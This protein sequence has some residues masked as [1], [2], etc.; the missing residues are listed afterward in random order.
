MDASFAK[1]LSHCR[2]DSVSRSAVNLCR[3]ARSVLVDNQADTAMLM[4]THCCYLAHNTTRQH[5]STHRVGPLMTHPSWMC[6]HPKG[7]RQRH[8]QYTG[9]VRREAV[10]GSS[11]ELSY[12]NIE[13]VRSFGFISR[14]YMI[15]STA[16]CTEFEFIIVSRNE[17]MITCTNTT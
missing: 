1:D 3:C 16:C 11:H 2:S 8:P 12:S 4:D 9:A 17:Q 15:V 10:G 5:S 6:H 13:I 14:A 7:S